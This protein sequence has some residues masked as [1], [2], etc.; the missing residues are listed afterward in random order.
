MLKEQLL[1]EAKQIDVSV[2]LDN[3]FE[4]VELSPEVKENFESVYAQAV[5]ANAVALAES[6]IAKIAEK[7]DEL[8]ES[9]VA[10]ARNE[11]ESK[12][13]EDADKFL[14]HLGEKWLKE[15]EVA[16][17]RNI[18][19]DLCESLISN[20]KDV[21]VSHNV[22]VPE[23]AVDVVA[24]LDEALKEEKEKTTELFDAKLQLESE[25]RTMKRDNAIMESTRDLTDTQKE[26]VNSLIEGLDYSESFESKLGVI[27]EMV[28]KKEEKKSETITESL[29]TDTEKLNVVTESTSDTENKKPVDNV[30]S[31][32]LHASLR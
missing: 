15:N 30:M 13:Y 24:E 19:A 26:K 8:V 7:A 3:I 32:Y 4:S 18:K 12:L 17:N 28:S 9:K 14:S 6:H 10:E 1:E 23:E 2:E 29:N 16:I 27:V 21:F 20:L 11:I 22:V 31:R 25:I 5:K